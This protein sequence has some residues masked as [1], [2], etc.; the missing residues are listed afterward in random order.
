MQTCVNFQ[1]ALKR[2]CGSPGLPSPSSCKFLKVKTASPWASHLLGWR[3]F[4]DNFSEWRVKY[5][6]VGKPP[7]RMKMIKRQ[8]LL[9]ASGVSSYLRDPPRLFKPGEH[10]GGWGRGLV[11]QQLSLQKTSFC[12]A[13]STKYT[14]FINTRCTFSYTNMSSPIPNTPP[15]YYQIDHSKYQ[16]DH[17]KYL[18]CHPKY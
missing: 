5:F 3:W 9:T 1:I 7:F 10:Q 6:T 18:I 16:I 17:P 8:L 13:H 12:L 15:Q 14:T 2:L 4:W 11:G